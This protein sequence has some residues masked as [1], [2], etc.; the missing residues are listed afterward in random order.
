M[1]VLFDTNVVLDVL[2]ARQ[3]HADVAAQLFVLI[4]N[5][6]LSGAICATTVTTVHYIATKS[7]GRQ[8]ARHHLHELLELFD[9]AAV[10]RN[11][12]GKALDLGFDDF[13][14]AVLHEA[15]A[16]SGMT[17]IVTRNTK[18]FAHATLPVFDPHELLAALLAASD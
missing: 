4:D 18:D 9:I 7:V 16:A 12:L 11:V 8:Q 2:L 14:D 15:A 1:K 3:P 17:A 6:R 10:D 5:G 13:E